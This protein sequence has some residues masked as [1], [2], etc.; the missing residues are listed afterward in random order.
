MKAGKQRRMLAESIIATSHG[1]GS[2][3]GSGKR[4]AK[5][6]KSTPSTRVTPEA[7]VP[8]V[9]PDVVEPRSL[10]FE[11]TEPA[12]TPGSVCVCV[13]HVTYTYIYIYM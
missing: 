11:E 3:E 7:K 4:S 12:D 9:A 2:S 10:E 13:D 8:C 6:V 1:S 5:D